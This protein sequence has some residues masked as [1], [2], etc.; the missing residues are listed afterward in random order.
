[1]QISIQDQYLPSPFPVTATRSHHPF[2]LQQLYTRTDT[3]VSLFIFM[4]RTIPDWNNL[5]SEKIN[6]LNL[7]QAHA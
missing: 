7:T 1:M 2:K 3:Y 6:E 5:C 4:P